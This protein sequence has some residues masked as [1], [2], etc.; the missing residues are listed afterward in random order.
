MNTSSSQKINQ[1]S[2]QISR[3]VINRYQFFCTGVLFICYLL[4][5]KKCIQTMLFSMIFSKCIYLRNNGMSHYDL[6]VAGC[7]GGRSARAF[8]GPAA[9]EQQRCHRACYLQQQ[10]Q[11][12]GAG[13]H[14]PVARQ[15]RLRLLHTAQS[16]YA[17]NTRGS[18]FKRGREASKL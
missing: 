14:V 11:R 6:P 5:R 7:M 9:C 13:R 17:R 3:A 18:F 10:Q 8:V 12:C 1:F 16:T 2:V 4:H 15:I